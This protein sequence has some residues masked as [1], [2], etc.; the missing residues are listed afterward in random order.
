[1]LLLS[2]SISEYTQIATSIIA[3]VACVF[4]CAQIWKKIEMSHAEQVA[5]MLDKV[6][7][8]PELI[9]LYYKI[10]YAGSTSWYNKDF[11]KKE[12]EKTMDEFLCHY[13]YVLL[14]RKR[15]LLRKGEFQFFEYFILRIIRNRGMQDYFY[16]LYHFT[17]QA[18]IKFPYPKLLS[19]MKNDK[20]LDF[21]EF[22]KDDSDNF[23]KVLNF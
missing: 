18:G 5:K 9:D 4:T 21:D 2:I 6:W 23:V 16:N 20:H 19:Y 7:S 14:L 11:H 22:L 3:F 13:E 8:K 1:M 12:T 10:E 17:K 15:C